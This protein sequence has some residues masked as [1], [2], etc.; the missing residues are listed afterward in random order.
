VLGSGATVLIMI[1]Y[2]AIDRQTTLESAPQSSAPTQGNRGVL[3]QRFSQ[4]APPATHGSRL[5]TSPVAVANS[6]KPIANDAVGRAEEETT[7]LPP[8]LQQRLETDPDPGIAKFHAEMSREP[9]DPVWAAATEYQIQGAL[10][11][12]AP[13]IIGRMQFFQTTCASSMCEMAAVLDDLDPAQASKDV[14]DWQARIHQASRLD[15]W[16]STGLGPPVDLLLS[17]DPEGHPVF[18]IQFR[19]GVSSRNKSLANRARLTRG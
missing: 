12:L 4:P 6:A 16:K 5:T 10:Q 18:I 19:K 2:R 13:D 17:V 8:Y 11:E 1:A 3:G 7:P 9:R 15:N 14:E